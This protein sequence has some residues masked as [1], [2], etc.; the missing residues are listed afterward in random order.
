MATRHTK[1]R[2]LEVMMKVDPEFK[3]NLLIK[4]YFEN[5]KKFETVVNEVDD[6]DDDTHE[7]QQIT[8]EEQQ[9]ALE[10]N[11]KAET[12]V[13]S[14]E[15]I[16]KPVV[17]NNMKGL[18]FT[19][20]VPTYK[21][22]LADQYVE[23]LKKLARKLRIPEPEVIEGSVYQK[24]HTEP[25]E[26]PPCDQY[27]IDVYDLTVK[28][29]GMF[30]FP[31]NYKLVAVVDNMTSG[32]IEIDKEEV[33]PKEFL[34]PSGECN[35]CNQERYR[36][37]N[38]IVKDGNSGKYLRLGSSCVKK[39]IGI[40]PAKY[41]R[42]LDYLRDFMRDMGGVA[43][44]DMWG[45]QGGGGRRGLDP[46]NRI[47]DINKVI[48]TLHDVLSSEP[49]VK[50]EWEYPDRGPRY[51]TNDGKASADKAE[52]IIHNREELDKYPI[53]TQ[54]VA[55]FK[56]FAN[57][58][59]P[60]PPNI[61]KYTDDYS[62]EQT[63]YDKNAGF[64]EYRAKIKVFGTDANFRIKDTAFLASA[65]NFFENEKKRSAEAKE[66]KDSQWIGN[67]DEKIK[68]PYAKLMDMRSGEGQFGVWYLWTFIDDKGNILKKFGT[69]DSK[70]RIEKAPEGSEEIGYRDFRKGDVFAFTSDIKKHDEYNGMK[71]TQLGRFSKL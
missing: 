64:N 55:E 15:D 10:L 4:E 21:K 3:E 38:F 53:N 33:V 49:Y 43:D 34:Q 17:D 5:P 27:L 56:E 31:G 20:T 59:E 11:K 19:V 25:C 39:Y 69:L 70:F 42:T 30:K 41:I 1:E 47:V 48:S 37:K 13:E 51:R 46:S 23:S 9:K 28:T 14:D 35:L 54:Y 62:G 71:N 26:I 68:I 32:S 12:A 16:N 40:N 63:E 67:V 52:K 2:L 29:E 66:R 6:V 8:P 36:G 44:D 57:S 7:E 24:R 60:I 22:R 58:L 50:R 65:I 18:S 45:A 61:V